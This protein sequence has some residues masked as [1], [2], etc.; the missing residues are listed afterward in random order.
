[1]H[2]LLCKLNFQTQNQ[3]TK[4]KKEQSRVGEKERMQSTCMAQGDG[5]ESSLW[6]PSCREE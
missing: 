2:A 6:T 5:H 1:M 3:E 4:K